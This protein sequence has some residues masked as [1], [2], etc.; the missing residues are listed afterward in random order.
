MPL[1]LNFSIRALVFKQ[2][3]GVSL[4]VVAVVFDDAVLCEFHQV[5]VLLRRQEETKGLVNKAARADNL[6]NVDLLVQLVSR[7]LELLQPSHLAA[8]FTLE[9]LGNGV[10]EPL[11]AV[12]KPGRLHLE[13]DVVWPLLPII[14]ARSSLDH[15]QPRGHVVVEVVVIEDAEQEA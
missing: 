4:A 15:V 9:E 10:D 14:T 8:A 3:H 2:H 7:S 1:N 6:D 12:K 5:C 11:E 13:V